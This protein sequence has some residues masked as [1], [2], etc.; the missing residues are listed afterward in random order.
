MSGLDS[1]YA[2]GLNSRIGKIYKYIKIAVAIEYS[3]V[4]Q[5]VLWL[6]LWTLAVLFANPRIRKRGL[7]IF[8]QILHVGMSR[9]RIEVEVILFDVFAV[10]A[11]VSGQ[12][13]KTLLEDRVLSVPEGQGKTQALVAVTN[14]GQATFLS[15]INA[16]LCVIVRKIIPGFSPPAIVL[17]HRPPPPFTDR[18]PPA[19][20]VLRPLMRLLESELL[21]SHQMSPLD[22]CRILMAVSPSS[23]TDMLSNRFSL[24]ET[25][26]NQRNPMFCWLA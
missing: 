19:L 1:V 18:W 15:T 13:K 17:A 3:G 6:G 8:V 14:T 5:L 16:R 11:F 22:A 7:R 20:P 4:E 25:F 23:C 24:P 9:C 2:N 21:S 12:A 10:I 26:W